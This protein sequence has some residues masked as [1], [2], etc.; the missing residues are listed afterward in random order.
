MKCIVTQRVLGSRNTCLASGMTNNGN[1][2]PPISPLLMT[3]GSSSVHVRGQEKLKATHFMKRLILIFYSTRRAFHSEHTSRMLHVHG[4]PCARVGLVISLGVG[5]TSRE[6]AQHADLV[7]RFANINLSAA[8]VA[9]AK[10]RAT[11]TRARVMP[12]PA[13]LARSTG[14]L[15]L[16]FR[17]GYIFR[18]LQHTNG[19]SVM[20]HLW[21]AS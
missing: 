20:H 2:I 17:I 9:A 4:R 7:A 13:N 11:R 12:Y 15:L 19:M 16:L 3:A 10:R 1:L 14:A 8:A 21:A 6:P 18:K 5:R